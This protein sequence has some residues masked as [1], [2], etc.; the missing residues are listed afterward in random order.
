[1][2]KGMQDSH[3][4]STPKQHFKSKTADGTPTTAEKVFNTHSTHIIKTESELTETATAAVED[5]QPKQEELSVQSNGK[6]VERS[7]STAIGKI[8]Y[9]KTFTCLVTNFLFAVQNGSLPIV[10]NNKDYSSITS[11]NKCR[12]VVSPHPP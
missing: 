2:K 3:P 8:R 12:F 6:S 11:N 7:P 10:S 1:M 5:S 4:T 9:K